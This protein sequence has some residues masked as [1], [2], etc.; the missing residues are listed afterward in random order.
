MLLNRAADAVVAATV[1]TLFVA[2]YRDIVFRACRFYFC[3]VLE[4]TVWR[5][6]RTGAKG[7]RN[8]LW[9][10]MRRL[11]FRCGSCSASS[12]S[13]CVVQSLR[14]QTRPALLRLCGQ[15][16]CWTFVAQVLKS[17]L[18]QIL[19]GTKFGMLC[20]CLRYCRA[21]PQLEACR[22]GLNG[23]ELQSLYDQAPE[24]ISIIFMGCGSG[25]HGRFLVRAY[26]WA[27]HS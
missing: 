3:E 12:T 26:F 15:L 8:T 14:P 6:C 25:D 23:Y 16:N 22:S 19:P 24:H 20:G 2:K 4:L 21:A 27:G 5:A 9:H 18:C 13:K 11:L 10:R 1:P 7:L 17:N